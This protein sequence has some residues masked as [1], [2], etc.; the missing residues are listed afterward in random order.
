ML[1]ISFWRFLLQFWDLKKFKKFL[2]K[3]IK[4]SLEFFFHWFLIVF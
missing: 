1:E 3:K 2:Q 4:K